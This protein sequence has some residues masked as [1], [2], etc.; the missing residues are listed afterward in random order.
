MLDSEH[1]DKAKRL[2]GKNISIFY[3][4]ISMPLSTRKHGGYEVESGS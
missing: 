3:F 1:K 4:K 2:Y